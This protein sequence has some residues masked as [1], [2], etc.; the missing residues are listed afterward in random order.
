MKYWIFFILIIAMGTGLTAQSFD[1]VWET[2]KVLKTPESVLYDAKRNQCYVSNINGKPMDKDANGF[3]SIVDTSG[4][5]TNLKWVA[6]MHAP[7][8]MVQ[9]DS[10]LYVTDIDCIRI[11]DIDQ[12]K[13]IKS[14]DVPGAVFLND[15]AMLPNGEIIVTDMKKDQL[16]IF[17]GNKVEVWLEDELLDSPNGLAFFKESLYVGTKHNILKAN[18]TTKK[19]KVHIEEAG[20]VDG[21][22]AI[23][24]N[25]FVVSD[26]S[27]RIIIAGL[28][29]KVFLQNT[30][31]QN[32][33]AAD[34]GYIPD[35]KL[36]LIP[37]FF[38]N[39]VV[40]KRLR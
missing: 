18:Y 28:N 2:E 9:S 24:T 5:I 3:I 39:R 13:L 38:D 10:L 11:I 19:L 25:K 40:A 8:G 35:Q 6:G 17:D 16:L 12:G 26:W 14:V 30:A 23:G 21:L 20:P 4:Q 7:K 36:I 22:I 34:L 15:M 27:G 32:I 33:Q 29:E 31:D 37:T 1:P